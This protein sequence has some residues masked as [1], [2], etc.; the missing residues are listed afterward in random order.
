MEQ[1]MAVE[2]NVTALKAAKF[3]GPVRFYDG[4]NGWA[5]QD[6]ECVDEPRFGYYWMRENHK[7]RGNQWY[8][9]DGD[10][11]GNLEEAC[12]RLAA[13]PDPE[14]KDNLRKRSWDEH[15]NSPKLNH[16]A[17][18]ALSEARCN[19]DAGPYGMMRAWLQRIQQPYHSGINRLSDMARRDGEEWPH[20]LYQAKS[21]AQ[22]TYRGQYLFAADREK[23]TG[24][25][26]A[27]GKSCRD[28]PIL[29]TIEASIVEARTSGAF[30]YPSDD[31][32]VDAAKVWTCIQHIQSS[33]VQPMD[34]VFFSTKADRDE[35][36]PW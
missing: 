8:T 29:Q 17:S 11:V 26:C 35:V 3:K 33:G 2:L 10:E 21:A 34:G 31:A 25:Q 13:A 12:R 15:S 1:L 20:W 6:F 30:S 16:G 7:D 27:L 5:R 14:C 36:H 28:C 9:V 24:L 18:R 32:D 4:R 22:E 23:A 19:A